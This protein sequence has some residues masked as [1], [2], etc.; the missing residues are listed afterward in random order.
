MKTFGVIG[1]FKQ[2]LLNTNIISKITLARMRKHWIRVISDEETE[3]LVYNIHPELLSVLEISGKRWGNIFP[4]KKYTS[5]KYPDFNILNIE[6]YQNTYD[7][8]ILE[9]VLEHIKSPLIALKNIYKLLN[10]NGFVLITTPFLVKLHFGPIDCTRWTKIGMKQLV[11][12][13]GFD[14]NYIEVNQWGNKSCIKANLKNWKKFNPIF[15]SLKNESN[16]PAIIWCLA[17]K[18]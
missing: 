17:K 18:L 6:N 9:H 10:P 8:I 13:A 5:Y 11:I 3:K 2:I 14:K 7:L 15:H 12:D 4:F 1:W 16:F